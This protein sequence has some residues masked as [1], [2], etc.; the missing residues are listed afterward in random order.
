MV[1][2]V[3]M[4]RRDMGW[5]IF[6]VVMRNELLKLASP[7]RAPDFVIHAKRDSTTDKGLL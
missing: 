1:I 5:V 2:V 3:F 6:T 4:K 7:S